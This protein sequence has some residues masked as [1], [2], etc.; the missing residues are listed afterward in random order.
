MFMGHV[1]QIVVRNALMSLC[2]A[3]ARFSFFCHCPFKFKQW[4]ITKYSVV[5]GVAVIIIVWRPGHVDHRVILVTQYSL[6]IIQSLSCAK[7]LLS[8]LEHPG[9]AN[10]SH[11]LQQF[12]LYGRGIGL[13]V[14]RILIQS[15]Q[16]NVIA[17]SRTRTPELLELSGP[18]L[19]ALECDV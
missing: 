10:T 11:T 6:K 17:L 16:A 2:I 9:I 19:L 12:T 18:S 3:K 5:A 15:L 13:A 14:T 8:L 7:P 1:Y 4:E